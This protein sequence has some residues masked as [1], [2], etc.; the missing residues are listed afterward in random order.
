[1][2]KPFCHVCVTRLLPFLFWVFWSVTSNSQ[3]A[4]EL[5][6]QAM[7]EYVDRD[8]SEL[9]M[10]KITA[11]TD[12]QSDPSQADSRRF[13]TTLTTLVSKEHELEFRSGSRDVWRLYASDTLGA[14]GNGS[15]EN[16]DW[17]RWT[18]GLRSYTKARD[19]DRL[20]IDG[21]EPSTGTCRYIDPFFYP[22][23]GTMTFTMQQ[24][25]AA[26]GSTYKLFFENLKCKHAVSKGQVISS[27]WRYVDQRSSAV[28]FLDIKD[29]L[30]MVVQFCELPKKS[31]PVEQLLQERDKLHC[32]GR[33]KVT[34]G[35]LE[36]VVV[37]LHCES[38]FMNQRNLIDM[39]RTDFTVVASRRKL[40]PE[41]EQ[42]LDR[43]KA[44]D[45]KKSS[46]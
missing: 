27:V 15:L 8:F 34:W 20:L 28:V 41:V 42:L 6:E 44:V 46:D 19:G 39:A 1:M 22:F 33:T 30:P 45:S 17:N 36:N 4:I 37:P 21:E 43:A 26:P 38:S 13:K 35:K 9:K 12:Y 5:A 14:I 11:V 16:C 7:A 31:V 3:D 18:I 29:D 32:Y 24:G 10:H 23:A 2:R 40:L 25:G